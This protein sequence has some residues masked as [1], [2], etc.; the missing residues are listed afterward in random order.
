MI[1]EDPSAGPQLSINFL[2]LCSLITLSLRSSSLHESPFTSS[3]Q[4][5]AAAPASGRSAWY[6]QATAHPTIPIPY[7]LDTMSKRPIRVLIFLMSRSMHVFWVCRPRA[8]QGCCPSWGCTPGLSPQT[9]ARYLTTCQSS[10]RAPQHVHAGFLLR[11]HHCRQMLC[12][13]PSPAYILT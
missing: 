10:R 6:T 11:Q 1:L 5:P 12:P 3:S 4:R 13:C 7:N 9:R 2:S 8:P